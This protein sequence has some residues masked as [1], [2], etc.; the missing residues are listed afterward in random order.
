LPIRGRKVCID[1]SIVEVEREGWM[2]VAKEPTERV[3]AMGDQHRQ[4]SKHRGLS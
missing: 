4:G 3:R 1:G 2:P